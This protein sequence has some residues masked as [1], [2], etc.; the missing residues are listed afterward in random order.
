MG[1]WG[2]GSWLSERIDHYRFLM[3][4]TDNENEKAAYAKI[5][6]DLESKKAEKDAE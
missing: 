3:E 5:I 1:L 6:A 2:W 4:T